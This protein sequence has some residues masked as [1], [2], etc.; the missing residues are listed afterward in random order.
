MSYFREISILKGAIVF[1]GRQVIPREL[2]GFCGFLLTSP[3]F[4]YEVVVIIP[5]RF[6]AVRVRGVTPVVQVILEE[7]RSALS[8]VSELDFLHDDLHRVLNPVSVDYD[9]EVRFVIEVRRTADVIQGGGFDYSVLILG[10]L[11]GVCHQ[12]NKNIILLCKIG[13]PV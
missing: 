10:L 9:T 7:S 6:N 5:L 11:C 2:S 4:L 13:Q 8:E 1:G 12:N 3:L